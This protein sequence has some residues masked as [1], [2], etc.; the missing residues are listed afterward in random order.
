LN[1]IFLLDF[2][3]CS[4]MWQDIS[5]YSIKKKKRFCGCKGQMTSKVDNKFT[6]KS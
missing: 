2:W 1:T 6:L 3:K 4:A 5:S